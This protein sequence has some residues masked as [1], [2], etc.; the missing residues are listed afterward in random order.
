MGWSRTKKEKEVGLTR[1]M[2]D[3]SEVIVAIIKER[4]TES[5][6][7][8]KEKKRLFAFGRPEAKA[9]P[10]RHRASRN[11]NI[12]HAVNVQLH[13]F[14]FFISIMLARY[15][16]PETHTTLSSSLT[17][18]FLPPSLPPYTLNE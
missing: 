6:A 11:T 18:P 17:S 15:L 4:D 1:R 9:G 12:K 10:C 7:Q 14:F 3:M 13:F 5:P 8:S 2:R 16:N